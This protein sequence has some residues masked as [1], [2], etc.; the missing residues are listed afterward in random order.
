ME[1]RVPAGSDGPLHRRHVLR[2][3]R[4]RGAAAVGRAPRRRPEALGPDGGRQAA[5]GSHGE[6]HQQSSREGSSPVRPTM[7]LSTRSLFLSYLLISL[8]NHP[9]MYFLI[10]STSTS[11]RSKTFVVS[12]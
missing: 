8:F 5:V 10:Y 7:Y 4:L 6:L 2:G 11:L 12:H 9:I 3:V 1:A